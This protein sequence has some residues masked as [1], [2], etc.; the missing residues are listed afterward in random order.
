[1]QRQK[2]LT[3]ALII[4]GALIVI[5]GV[6]LALTVPQEVKDIAQVHR[7]KML[8]GEWGPEKALGTWEE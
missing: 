8:S 1:M 4:I 7:Q 2:T 5:L 3:K 6:T